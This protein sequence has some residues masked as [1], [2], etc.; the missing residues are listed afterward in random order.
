MHPLSSNSPNP[1]KFSVLCGTSLK[2]STLESHSQYFGY[3]REKK[4]KRT[5]ISILE[6]STYKT[7]PIQGINL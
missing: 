1:V 6:T 3:E 4:K 5:K 2:L 7:N